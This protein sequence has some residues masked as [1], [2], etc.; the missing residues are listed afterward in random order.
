MNFERKAFRMGVAVLVGAILLRLLGGLPDTPVQPRLAQLLLFLQTGRL[1]RLEEPTIAFTPTEPEAQEN[2]IADLP[3]VPVFSAEDASSV[4]LRNT[5]GYS[6]D[7]AQLLTQPLDWSLTG[8]EPT[9]LILHT[10]SSESYAD[11]AGFRSRD[12]SR[13]MLAVGDRLAAQLEEAGISVIHDRTAHDAESYNGSYAHAR[14]SLEQYLARYPTIRLVLDLHRDAAED[15]DGNQIN[16]TVDTP[17]GQAAKLML[18][19]GTDAGGMTHPTWQNNL[20][21][22]VKLHAQLQT[23]CPEICRPLQL[24]TSR[25]NQDLSPGALLVEVGAAGNTMPEALLATDILARGIVALTHG[26][27]LQ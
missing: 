14:T 24:R 12:E 23:L 8:P 16:Y 26:A 2:T 20:A 21:L 6:V 5:S 18:V 4:Q 22:A 13:N 19:M 7:T 25:F 9:V 3:V 1:A 11:T 15:A 27:N 10:H 17:E